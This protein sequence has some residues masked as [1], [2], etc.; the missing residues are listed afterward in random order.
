MTQRL[1]SYKFFGQS[2]SS[3]GTFDTCPRKYEGSYITREAVW[4]ETE[5]NAYGIRMHTA[6][7]GAL[8]HQQP[9]PEEFAQLQPVMEQVRQWPRLFVEKEFAVDAQWKPTEWKYRWLGARIDVASWGDGKKARV[10]DWKTGKPRDDYLQLDINAALLLSISGTVERVTA[11]YLYTRTE[12]LSKRVYL[13]ADL[14]EL[15][16]TLAQ[17]IIRIQAAHEAKNFPPQPNGLCRNYCEVFS[18]EFNG[19]RG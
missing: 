9:V 3:I 2:P 12:S 4:K 11:A 1:I 5:A 7:E 15:R 14:P 17:K 16:A 8:I 6:A 13:R 19:R 18:C 10:L